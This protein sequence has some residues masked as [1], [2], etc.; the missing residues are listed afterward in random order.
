[1]GPVDDVQ[2]GAAGDDRV[3]DPLAGAEADVA[4]VDPLAEGEPV[5]VALHLDEERPEPRG[6]A[7]LA[8]GVRALVVDRSLRVEVVT[9]LEGIAGAGRKQIRPAPAFTQHDRV[10]E[11]RHDG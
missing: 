11:V 2:S 4:L 6:T 3:L 7:G 9:R 5:A 8:A 10:P 1:A